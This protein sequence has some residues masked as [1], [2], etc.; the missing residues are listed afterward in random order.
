[1]A[2]H[3]AMRFSFFV[4]VQVIEME[5]LFMAPDHCRVDLAQMLR[6]VQAQEKQKLHLVQPSMYSFAMLSLVPKESL[7]L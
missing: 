7:R 5:S 4:M 2:V 1:M 3:V 6:A